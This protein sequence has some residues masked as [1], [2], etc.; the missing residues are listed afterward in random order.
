MGFSISG[1]NGDSIQ[2]VR[3]VNE[4]KPLERSMTEEIKHAAKD[5][6][7]AM[8][9]PKELQEQA[10]GMNKMLEASYTDLKF[11]VHEDLDRI[12]VQVLERETEEV[13]REIPPEKFLDMVASMLEQVGILV[14]EKV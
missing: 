2:T 11:N 12:Y 7:P 1:S 6:R 13:V 4:G 9:D 5:H 14:D 3:S 8:L 10:D